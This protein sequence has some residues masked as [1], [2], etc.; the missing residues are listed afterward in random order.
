MALTMKGDIVSRAYSKMR[1]SG[2]TVDPRPEENDLAVNMLE[3]IAH[4]LS[5]PGWKFE[6]NPDTSSTH[7]LELKFVEHL[8]A[9]L[10]VRLAA[11]FEKI[12]PLLISQGSAAASFIASNTATIPKSSYPSRM[13]KGSGNR[14]CLTGTFYDPIY[15]GEGVAIAENVMI[16]GEI[17]NFTESFDSYLNSGEDVSS[18]TI[19]AGTACITV[20]SSSLT[21][22]IV[23]YKI[24]AATSSDDIANVTITATTSTGRKKIRTIPFRVNEA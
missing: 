3:I 7:G 11:D 12:N 6:T 5:L 4:E 9:L 18:F 24:E 2:I 16:I 15:S 8:A 13:P 10:A 1:I 14:L 21:T 22:P 19:E 23:T 20:V 17:D